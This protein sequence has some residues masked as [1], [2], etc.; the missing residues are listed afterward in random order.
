MKILK[1]AAQIVGTLWRILFTIA[2]LFGI[3]KQSFDLSTTYGAGYF[4]GTCLAMIGIM[5]IGYFL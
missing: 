4:L 2:F 1:V 5:S 3:T